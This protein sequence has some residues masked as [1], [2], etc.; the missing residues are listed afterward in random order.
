MQPQCSSQTPSHKPN[1]A[2][3]DGN[4]EATL[5][6]SDEVLDDFVITVSTIGRFLSEFGSDHSDCSAIKEASDRLVCAGSMSLV[7][8]PV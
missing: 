6:R 4:C 1:G 5:D 8:A 3:G 2:T 7:E